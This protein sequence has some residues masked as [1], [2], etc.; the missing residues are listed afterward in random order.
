MIIAA[1]AVAVQAAP[2]AGASGPFS[3]K[4]GKRKFS[5]LYK[6]NPKYVHNTTTAL[7]NAYAKHNLTP[8]GKV[9]HAFQD[10]L[11]RHQSKHRYAKCWSSYQYHISV[12]LATNQVLP[13]C[14]DTGSSTFWVP[15]TELPPSLQNT[16]ALYSPS[17]SATYVA[18]PASSKF[19]ITYGSGGWSSGTCGL[20]TVQ[21]GDSQDMT[22]DMV[23]FRG[24][25]I[26]LENSASDGYAQQDML[27]L[28]P[29]NGQTPCRD[30]QNFFGSIVS[31]LKSP[32]FAVY[33]P[34]AVDGYYDWGYT[35]DSRHTGTI[36]YTAVTS[37]NGYWKYPSVQYKVGDTTYNIAGQTRISDTG[38]AGIL[39]LNATL[40][41]YYMSAKVGGV[42]S[43]NIWQFPCSSK[44]PSFSFL[45]GDTIWA[46]IP[47]SLL[48][49][50]TTNS[51]GTMCAGLLQDRGS[52]PKNIYGELMFNAYYGVFGY[53]SDNSLQ[54]GIAPIVPP[55]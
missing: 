25:G 35:E 3:S 21:V 41:Q 48:N 43:N 28:A 39:M 13:M 38:T 6:R 44:L 20:E 49:S 31:L 47:G 33:L 30:T 46:T 26:G 16:Q 51:A 5:T 27:G 24:F 34:G 18:L 11:D 45:V 12:L 23:G 17:E 22:G 52:F 7:L 2:T 50:G 40:E 10:A 19:D 14:L 42:F 32:L 55:S 4:G 36:Q 37:S 1:L 54:F 29:L 9:S 53:A 15:S 8:T